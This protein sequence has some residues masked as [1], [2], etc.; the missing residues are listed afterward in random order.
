MDEKKEIDEVKKEGKDKQTP[1]GTGD[2]NNYSANPEIERINAD[3]ER[4]E[5][6]IA[7]NANARAR[8]ELGGDTE[9]GQKAPVVSRDQKKRDNAAEYFEGTQLEIDILK[10][11]A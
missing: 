10:A 3:T 1:E 9:A 4:I 5:K 8:L 11:N 2:R 6:A 7:D